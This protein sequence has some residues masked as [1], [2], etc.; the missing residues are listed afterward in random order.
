MEPS[1]NQLTSLWDPD[2]DIRAQGEAFLLPSRDKARLM[3]HDEDHLRHDALKLFGQAF[4]MACLVDAKA[5]DR[6]S[7]ENQRIKE[8]MELQK[9]V[10][11]LQA[12]INRVNNLHQETK[13]IQAEKAQDALILAEERSKILSKVKELKKEVS[14]RGE[15]LTNATK[16]FKQD[17]T[18]SY[19]VGFEAALEL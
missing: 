13:R 5:K 3:V 18:Q 7:V 11:C 10:E 6:R 9:E 2:F 15:N 17:A 4:V 1:K 19:F 8:N 14:H 16:P 12:E